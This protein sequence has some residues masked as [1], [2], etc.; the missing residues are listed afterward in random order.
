MLHN[1]VTTNECEDKEH[2][3]FQLGSVKT[4]SVV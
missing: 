3:S 4:A 2:F 1:I